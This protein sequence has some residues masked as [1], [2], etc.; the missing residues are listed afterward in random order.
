ML[1]SDENIKALFD[2]GLSPNQS[3]VYLSVL[4][5]DGLPVQ[6]IS[7]LAGVNR[8]EVY[9][10]IQR[11]EKMGLIEKVMGN[12]TR[13]RSLPVE[14]ALA[15]MIKVERNTFAERM[16]RLDV[17]TSEFVKRYNKRSMQK[18]G[19]Q[20]EASDFVLLV[21]K[22]AIVN[23]GTTMISDAKNRV[24][25]VYSENQLLQFI[26]IFADPLESACKKGVTARLIA[27]KKVQETPAR[28]VIRRYLGECK[29]LQLKFAERP[30]SHSII[31]DRT[32]ALS[33]TS[34]EGY[35]S[36]IPHLWTNNKGL[37]EL[38]QVN[39]ESIWEIAKPD[40]NN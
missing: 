28:K 40:S 2:L 3:K 32:E 18:T 17:S 39:F 13:V 33:A 4:Q 12:P 37:V 19:T 34:V 36:E 20:E 21:E 6:D 31:V 1:V 25:A 30:T 23:K 7:K 38:L 15:N 35:F 14:V 11:L 16:S 24:D 9:R 26:P 27:D 29:G 5:T 22:N 8:E 10:V